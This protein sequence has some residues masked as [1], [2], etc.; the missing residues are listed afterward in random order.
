[1]NLGAVI[2]LSG[3]ECLG[4]SISHRSLYSGYISASCGAEYNQ[5]GLCVLFI[6]MHIPRCF[7][8]TFSQY[9]LSC[10]TV[11]WVG[12]Y[13]HPLEPSIK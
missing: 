12:H 10:L 1:M 2:W 5:E 9:D 3:N 6:H 13:L 7:R 8:G 11:S 4:L